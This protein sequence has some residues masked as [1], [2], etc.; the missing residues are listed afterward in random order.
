MIPFGNQVSDFWQGQLLAQMKVSDYYLKLPPLPSSPL[1][2]HFLIQGTNQRGGQYMA[3]APAFMG[4][5][6][7]SEN[8]SSVYGNAGWRGDSLTPYVSSVHLCFTLEK[9]KLVMSK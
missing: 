9:V 2:P 6:V 8:T 3:E 5:T 7:C 4:L 1:L